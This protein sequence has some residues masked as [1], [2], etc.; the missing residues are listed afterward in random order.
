MTGELIKYSIVRQEPWVLALRSIYE[1]EAAL[2]HLLL[3]TG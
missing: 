1:F 3:G 2:L